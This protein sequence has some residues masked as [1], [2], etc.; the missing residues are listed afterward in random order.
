MR[1][2]RIS[3]VG[4]TAVTVGLA[5][6]VTSWTARADLAGTVE[7]FESGHYQQA[8]E[9]LAQGS[10]QARPA[11]ESLWSSRLARDPQVALTA[12]ESSLDD[13]RCSEA[14]LL[15]IRLE[16]ANIQAGRGHHDEVL[17]LLEPLLAAGN[18]TLP[19]AVYLRAGISLRARGQLQRAREMFAS[20]RPADPA[21][22]LARY[23]LGDIGLEQEDPVLAIRYFES[24]AAAASEAAESRLADGLWRAQQLL[25]RTAEATAL[26]DRLVAEDPGCLALLEIHRLEQV[27]ADEFNAHQEAAVATD[28]LVTPVRETA[29]RF[30]LQLAAFSDRH[31]ALAFRKKYVDRVPDLRVVR[32]RDRLGQ[33]LYKI[34]SGEYVSPA[35]ARSQAGRLRADLGIEIIVADLSQAY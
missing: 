34:W 7:L 22:V 33:T 29:G 16:M 24:A 20:V 9:S 14:V 11:E 32:T 12:L 30:A 17:D 27:A 6:A 35:M 15:R 5:A 4:L 2:R 26:R 1:T 19:G 18:N 23:Y 3:K 21:F 10:G 8:A 31:L 28:S 13:R 25:D